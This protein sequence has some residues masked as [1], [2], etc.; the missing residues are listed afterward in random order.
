MIM[1]ILPQ[2]LLLPPKFLLALL[3]TLVVVQL[4]PIEACTFAGG[5]FALIL[6]LLLQLANLHVNLFALILLL[7]LD[8]LGL[9]RL[10]FL[11]MGRLRRLA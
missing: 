1:F 10:Q 2:T 8:P 9:K 7:L 11:S 4:Q 6:L 3:L 5:A